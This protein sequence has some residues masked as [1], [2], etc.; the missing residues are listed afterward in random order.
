M[1]H[2]ILEYFVIRECACSIIFRLIV[3]LYIY[4]CI[5]VRWNKLLFPKELIKARLCLPCCLICTCTILLKLW[6]A[7]YLECHNFIDYHFTD[8]NCQSL[9]KMCLNKV[10]LLSLLLSLSYTLFF[11]ANYL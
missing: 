2:S 6:S 9:N 10:I 7:Y 3:K 11:V 8:S 4:Q 5:H 1:L